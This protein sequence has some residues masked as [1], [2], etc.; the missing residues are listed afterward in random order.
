MVGEVKTRHNIKQFSVSGED[1]K[2]NAETLV[3]GLTIARN[4]ERL[5]TERC[6]Q[7]W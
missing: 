5:W 3:L 7:C 1:G 4:N 6:L 2:V